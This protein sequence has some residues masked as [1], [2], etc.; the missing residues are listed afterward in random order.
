M[1]IILGGLP[2]TGKT[3]VARLVAARLW[4]VHLRID[5]LEQAIRDSFLAPDDVADAG[6]RAAFAVAVDNL[7]LGHRVIADSVNPI[8]LS[9]AAWRAA[10]E[11]AEAP[12]VEIELVCSDAA[13]HRR[14][15][16]TRV[17]DMPGQSLPDWAAVEQRDY[18]PWTRP[19]LVLDT[20]TMGAEAAAE[21][22]VA[23]ARELA[24]EQ[25]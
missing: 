23:A 11:Q 7:R 19:R 25:E 9:R 15:V 18:E 6:Y 4:A 12:F 20:A 8:E 3:T 21:R 10:A 16:E 22:V 5:S 14:R 17:A 1:L 24:E 13:E 2:A